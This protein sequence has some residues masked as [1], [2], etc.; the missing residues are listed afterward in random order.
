M[1]INMK[2]HL[3]LYILCLFIRVKTQKMQNG[4]DAF[5][6]VTPKLQFRFTV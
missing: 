2:Q 4:L 5:L 3:N 6:I 1:P